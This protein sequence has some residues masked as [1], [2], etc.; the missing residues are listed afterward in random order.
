MKS[1]ANE[2]EAGESLEERIE[3]EFTDFRSE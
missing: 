1:K 2:V 3:I